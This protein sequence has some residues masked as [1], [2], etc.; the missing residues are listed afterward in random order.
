MK[1]SIIVLPALLVLGACAS[2]VIEESK[3][4][5][6]LA[7]HYRAFHLLDDAR[8]KALAAGEYVDPE[9]ERAW[10]AERPRFLYDRARSALFLEQPERA[11]ADLGALLA[12]DPD[13]AAAKTLRKDAI[14][15]LSEQK[16]ASAQLLL[17]K[18][19]YAN[20]MVAFLEA[21]SITPSPEA[22]A[23]Q[24]IVRKEVEKQ[25]TRAQQQFLEALRKLPEFRYTEVRWH[26]TIALADDPARRDAEALKHSAQAELVKQA[27]VRGRAD[28]EQQLFG[29]ALVEFQ[30]AKDLDPTTPGI[31]DEIA[32]VKRE[33]AAGAA[34]D[35]GQMLMRR[36]DL[37]GAKV[38]FD[39]AYEQSIV[40]RGTISE[41]MIEVRRRRGQ[42]EYD[43]ARDLE[44]QG[45]KREALAA[46]EA[47]ATG[48]PEG[49]DDEKARIDGL[50]T[51]VAAAEQEY[52]AGVA[53]EDAGKLEEA[54]EHFAASE[55]YYG[56]LRDAKARLTQ[57]REKLAK[58]VDG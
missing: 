49:F 44:I 2:S 42:R 43:A 13:N 14:K 11:L 3:A 41:L 37:D 20:A 55:R 5:S 18:R 52:A 4:N 56:K 19:D 33:L 48:W 26:S 58:K 30:G 7:Q 10:A 28:K 31:D 24:L 25:T 6:G 39:K 22:L 34:V 53:A 36:G 50:R 21:E 45:M 54:I 12:I 27:L 23:G 17:G 51:D 9:L 46:F 15:K 29:A 47:M 8:E 1:K 35:D 32:E 16:I 38:L 40:L 57:L